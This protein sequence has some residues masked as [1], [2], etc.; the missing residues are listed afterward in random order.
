MGLDLIL[1]PFATLAIGMTA[2]VLLRARVK[3]AQRS[4]RSRALVYARATARAKENAKQRRRDN[5]IL[6]DVRPT[7]MAAAPRPRSGNRRLE[8]STMIFVLIPAAV[9]DLYESDSRFAKPSG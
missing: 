8:V 6:R 4:P 2:F 7:P 1:T 5:A 3:K 9:I